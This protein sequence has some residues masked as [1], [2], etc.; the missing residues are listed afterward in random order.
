MIS[1][2]II[3][4]IDIVNSGEFEAR[5]DGVHRRQFKKIINEKLSLRADIS[6]RN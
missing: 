4:T 6:P 2:E 3:I 5:S 1:L